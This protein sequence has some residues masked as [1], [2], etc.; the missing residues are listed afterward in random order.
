MINFS[1]SDSI[2]L[3]ALDLLEKSG[4]SAFQNILLSVTDSISKVSK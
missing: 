2:L 1:S 4:T 3:L